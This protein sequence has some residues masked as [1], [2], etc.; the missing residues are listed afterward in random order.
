MDGVRPEDLLRLPHAGYLRRRGVGAFLMVG[1]GGE[2]FDDFHDYLHHLAGTLPEAYRAG[3]DYKD[4][5]DALAKVRRGELNA[6]AAASQMP[7]LR[8]VGGA[9]PCSKSVRWVVDA[10]PLDAAGQPAQ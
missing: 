3:R 4:Y 5:V 2:V 10:D 8:R 9:C 7:A 6:E 1:T